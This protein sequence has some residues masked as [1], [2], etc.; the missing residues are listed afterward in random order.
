MSTTN[1]NVNG[2]VDP[3]SR[4]QTACV[5]EKTIEV[6]LVV[7]NPADPI[8]RAISVMADKNPTHEIATQLNGLAVMKNEWARKYY[9]H[10]VDSI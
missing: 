10:I 6:G 4:T 5:W 7:L 8:K 1:D 2:T 3:L 9:F